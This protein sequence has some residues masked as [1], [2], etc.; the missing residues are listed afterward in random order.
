MF[1]L[2]TPVLVT[3]LTAEER[4]DEVSQWLESGDPSTMAISNW[5]VAEFSAALSRKLRDNRI[6]VS[7]RANSL[8]KFSNLA[9]HSFFRFPVEDRHFLAAARLSDREK[10]GLRAGDALH[11]A[12]AAENGA[13]L[14]TLDK[15]LA[16][17][18]LELGIATQ[19]I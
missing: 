16:R 8:G 1:Y 14:C 12:I 10:T 7:E 9:A 2:D 17:A 3:F 19:L 13:K 11:L 6:T 4:T 15:G 5:V 18:G